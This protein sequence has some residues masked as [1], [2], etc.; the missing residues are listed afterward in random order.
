MSSVGTIVHNIARFLVPILGSLAGKTEHHVKDSRQFSREVRELS[1][2]PGEVMTS[3]D[4]KSL[5]TCIPPQGALE[6]VRS[7][8]REDD[9]LGERTKLSVQ[10]VCDLLELCLTSVYFVFKGVFYTQKHGGAIG[11]PISPVVSDIYVENFERK[12]MVSFAGIPPRVWW[13]YVDDTFVIIKELIRESFFSHINTVDKYLQFTEEPMSDTRTIPFLDTLVSA[14]EDNSL[15]VHVFRKPTH[16]DQYLQFDSAHPLEHKLS[17]VRTLYHRAYT[18]VSQWDGILKEKEHVAKAL[19]V[20]GYPKWALEDTGSGAA[21]RAREAQ[22][23]ERKE[24]K[25]QGRVTIPYIQS[26]SEE[27]RRVLGSVNITTHFRPPGTLR[28]VLFHPKDKVPKGKKANVIYQVECGQCGEK[29]V[30]ETQQ[31]LSKRVHQ[32]TH[33]AAGRPNSGPHV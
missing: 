15:K 5:F 14:G 21:R 6:A 1:L 25:C 22:S 30:G 10:N 24:R 31:P 3:Y 29:Y 2:E 9:S 18:V 13:R 4:V 20:C 28:Q 19:S 7:R 11:S 17:V 32:H 27:I 16:T 26:V 8:L 12:A 23:G 33:S